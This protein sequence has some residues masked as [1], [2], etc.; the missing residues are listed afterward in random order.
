MNLGLKYG[1]GPDGAKT[2]TIPDERRAAVIAFVREGGAR[3]QVEI[4]S[5]A[6]E[7]HDALL[8]ALAGL[9]EP[10]A[11]FKPSANDWSILELMAHVVS[12]KQIVAT[13]C[14]NLGEGRLPAGFGPQFEEQAAQDGV[15]IARFATLAESLVAAEAAHADLLT[16][17]RGL[18]SATDG[19]AR[20]RHFLFGALN[21]R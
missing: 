8:A 6:Q 7:G 20:F 1:I 17:V 2:V 4:E 15:T 21:C 19:D 9:S 18:S 10:Q 13:L 5:I 16:T 11:A 12:T 3:T 14:R